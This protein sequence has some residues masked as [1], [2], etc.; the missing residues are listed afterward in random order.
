MKISWATKYSLA[1]L[2]FAATFGWW[3]LATWAY[4]H[5]HCQGGLKDLQ[6]CFAG[7]T[8]I[9]WY[10]GIGLFFCQ[11]LW[12]PAAILSAVLALGVFEMHN[13]ERIAKGPSPSSHVRCPDCRK[14]IPKESTVCRYCLC[15]LLPEA[16]IHGAATEAQPCSQQDAAR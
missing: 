15:K 14:I 6:P 13:R 9:T 2:P 1:T 5:F 4:S 3:Q 16:S 8:D 10:L 7:A 11:L 12:V